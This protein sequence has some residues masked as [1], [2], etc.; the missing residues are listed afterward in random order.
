[1]HLL[2]SSQI[3]SSG[4]ITDRIMVVTK[5]W[6]AD[7]KHEDKLEWK[8]YALAQWRLCTNCL[9]YSIPFGTG[10]GWGSM[11]VTS[12][13]NVKLFSF[14][15]KS[16]FLIKEMTIK[17]LSIRSSTKLKKGRHEKKTQWFHALIKNIWFDLQDMLHYKVVMRIH[18]KN[19]NMTFTFMTTVKKH[20]NVNYSGKTFVMQHL[21]IVLWS[22]VAIQ[23]IYADNTCT[24]MRH[25]IP[26]PH[27]TDWWPYKNVA[28]GMVVHK[29][30]LKRNAL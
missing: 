22:L 19:M 11:L 30:I 24:N 20:H 1:M 10:I 23:L 25:E 17:C 5:Q 8:D 2:L 21:K 9:I 7:W 14:N 3:E 29:K 6:R 28:S 16:Q 18:T 27:T 26:P 12:Y 13:I 4:W 15:L